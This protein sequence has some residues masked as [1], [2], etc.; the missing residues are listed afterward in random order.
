MKR[1]HSDAAVQQKIALTVKDGKYTHNQRISI[2]TIHHFKRDVFGVARMLKRWQ[3]SRR[4]LGP[5]VILVWGS[6]ELH[7]R[8]SGDIHMMARA[9]RHA[10]SPTS[11]MTA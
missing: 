7:V 4:S 11:G 6:T 10:L 3:R 5:S 1:R 8:K 9:I 2:A